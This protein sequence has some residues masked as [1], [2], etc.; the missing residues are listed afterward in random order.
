MKVKLAPEFEKLVN[1]ELQVGEYSSAGDVINAAM[2][3]FKE[4]DNDRATMYKVNAGEAFPNDRRFD[5]RLGMLLEEAEQCGEPTE[6][7]DE[8]WD[9]IERDAARILQARKIA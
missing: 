1:E 9:E 8:D 5:V 4:H 6:M 7:T 2:E 3:L